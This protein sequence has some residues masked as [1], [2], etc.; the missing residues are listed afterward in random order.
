LK[1]ELRI[2]EV[3]RV[4]IEKTV[5]FRLNSSK[6]EANYLQFYL[7]HVIMYSTKITCEG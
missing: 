3:Y 2:A 4:K 5:L 6:F 7:Y 1:N